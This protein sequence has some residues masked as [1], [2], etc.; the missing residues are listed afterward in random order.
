MISLVDLPQQVLDIVA[1]HIAQYDNGMLAGIGLEQFAEVG[2][3]GAEDDLV[4]GKGALVTGE[5]HIDEVLLVPQMAE[6]VEYRGL[7]VVPFECVML[8]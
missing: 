6:R 3:A 7:E 1:A 2:A 8:L 4:G 5:R